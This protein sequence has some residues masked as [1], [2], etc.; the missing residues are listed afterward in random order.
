[1]AAQHPRRSEYEIGKL[2]EMVRDREAWR[3]A[4]RGVAKSR[5]QLGDWTTATTNNKN[6]QEWISYLLPHSKL[7]H[8][9]L[10]Q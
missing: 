1:M 9:S 5:T 10:K 4:V 7:K 6:D 3:A 8:S 2:Q